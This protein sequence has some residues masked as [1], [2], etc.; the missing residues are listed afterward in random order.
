[1]RDDNPVAYALW[2][3]WY[4]LADNRPDG[5]LGDPVYDQWTRDCATVY[6]AAKAWACDCGKGEH[7]P[8]YGS[9]FNRT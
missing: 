8:Q 6:A 5:K 4:D 3:V 9:A 2:R 7:C 1:M